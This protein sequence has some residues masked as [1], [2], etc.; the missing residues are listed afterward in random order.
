MLSDF[1]LSKKTLVTKTVWYQNK[2]GY[3]GQGNRL[4]SQYKVKYTVNFTTKETGA[5]NRN[6][7]ITS[8]YG[9][10]KIG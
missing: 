9:V 10:E 3:M 4:E 7:K 2:S 5:F 1:K 6:R 8:I